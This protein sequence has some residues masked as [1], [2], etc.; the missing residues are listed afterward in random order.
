MRGLGACALAALLLPSS[1]TPGESQTRDQAVSSLTIFAGTGSGLFRSRD[2]GNTWEQ[3]KAP[4]LEG[5]GAVRAIVATGS[6]V[7]AGGDGG[8]C[9]SDDFGATWVKT[10]AASPALALAV[11]RSP[12]ADPTV[13][14][15]TP[16]GLRRSSDLGRNFAA[17]AL[18]GTPAFRIEWPG[19]DLVVATGRGVV[20][21]RAGSKA[22]ES[23]SG[24][25]EGRVA[26]LAVSSFFVVDPVA[27][28]GVPGQ[29]V[30]QS[31]DGARTWK[32]VGLPGRTVS[33]LLWFGPILYAATDAG[34]FQSD[35]V[36]ATWTA[37]NDGIERRV[38]T[39]ILFPFY[40][41]S[42]ADTFLGTDSGI[43]WTGDAAAHWRATGL[44]DEAILA[45]ATFPQPD[46]VQK[47][48]K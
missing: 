4:A 39:R 1:L 21:F 16:E 36:G 28:A 32:P 46:P 24:L 42:A 48:K 14:L 35:D 2:W 9:F 18:E 40:P 37:H 44:K 20:V 5:M 13:F 30:F 6:F 43:F 47:R 26:A 10:Y 31:R 41:A 7:F 12:L 33:D 22:Y 15:G 3:V 27:F 38:V 11:S 17:T 25:P 23:G 34:F 19:P 29:G 45:L 8:L